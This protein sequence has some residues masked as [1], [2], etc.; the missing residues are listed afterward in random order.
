MHRMLSDKQAKK[1]K[2]TRITFK[3]EGGT[4]SV[5]I[6]L[7]NPDTCNEGILTSRLHKTIDFPCKNSREIFENK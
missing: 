2:I 1:E 5:T 6:S 4:N 7:N 3:G